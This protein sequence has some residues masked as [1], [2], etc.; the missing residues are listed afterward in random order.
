MLSACQYIKRG[1]FPEDY[2][3]IQG[4]APETVLMRGGSMIVSPRG[5]VLAGPNFEGECILTADL[6][7]D[8]IARGKYDFDVVGHYAR[9]DVFRLLVDE[10]AQPAVLNSVGSFLA[11]D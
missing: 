4:N 7:L 11:S 2:D 6:D 9:P 10:S 8:D 5:E 1:A 3:A